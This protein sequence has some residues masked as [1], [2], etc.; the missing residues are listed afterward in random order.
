VDGNTVHD[1]DQRIAGVQ[2]RFLLA[3]ERE[4]VRRSAVSNPKPPSGGFFFSDPMKDTA[5][6]VAQTVAQ[7]APPWY[8][9]ALAWSD[10]NFPRV[11]L[12]LS[13][14]YTALQIYSS[15]KR[16]RKGDANVDE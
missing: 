7:I 16:L 10:A 13:V 12:T 9:T 3:R 2:P 4:P 1:N 5:S 11:L 14:I 8:A 15:I 6:A